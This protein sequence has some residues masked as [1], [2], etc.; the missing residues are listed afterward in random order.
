MNMM[1]KLTEPRDMAKMN[2]DD[3]SVEIGLFDEGDRE[4]TH[5]IVPLSRYLGE[6]R[7]PPAQPS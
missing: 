4:D 5:K 2:A 1:P 6:L 7:D 3:F